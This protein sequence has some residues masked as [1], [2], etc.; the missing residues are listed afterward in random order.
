M[1]N[2]CNRINGMWAFALY[3]E[4]K[5]QYMIGRDHAGIIPLYWGHDADGEKK[6][7]KN[8]RN[9]KKQ[10]EEKE[11]EKEKREQEKSLLVRC[12]LGFL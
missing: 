4:K 5:D 7:K 11:E 8:K 6:K 3:D 12:S 9:K 10:E 1:E 2:V